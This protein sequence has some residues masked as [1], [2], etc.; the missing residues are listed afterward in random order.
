MLSN[1]KWTVRA[2]TLSLFLYAFS[3]CATSQSSFVTSLDGDEVAALSTSLEQACG[4]Y[5]EVP[6]SLTGDPLIGQPDLWT[7]LEAAEGVIPGHALAEYYQQICEEGDGTGCTLL[8]LLHYLPE[9]S[10][11]R[12]QGDILVALDGFA[13]A[14]GPLE[15]GPACRLLA[16][17]FQ[18]E[19]QQ[20]FEDERQWELIDEYSERACLLGDGE[21]CRI[22]AESVDNQDDVQVRNAY[23]LRGCLQED[24][25]SCYELGVEAREQDRPGC[26]LAGMREACEMGLEDGC[27]ELEDLATQ[28]CGGRHNVDFCTEIAN[29]APVEERAHRTWRAA[30]EGYCQEGDDFACHLLTS[31]AMGHAASLS[32]L[33][34][35]EQPAPYQCIDG[36]TQRLSPSQ[37][38]GRYGCGATH[39]SQLRTSHHSPVEV[40][41]HAAQYE[42]LA[43][44]R[45]DDGSYPFA[46]PMAAAAARV[47]NVGKGGRCGHIVDL[48]DVVCPE[49]RY[50][51]YIDLYF[52]PAVP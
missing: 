11:L 18:Q 28:V 33:D 38:A 48:Y 6:S 31:A 36:E 15:F 40:C 27:R 2:L 23:L 5:G 42:Y 50:E 1:G 41:G 37:W 46:S 13:R 4:Q 14:C 39:Y 8:G 32:C 7:L 24:R 26:Y 3:A 29:I 19:G 21:A 12:R 30:Y 51:I 20:Y 16:I 9:E 25:R 22:I 49:G 45:C 44:L 17:F 35:N 43:N 10:T 34:L 52:C 47:G